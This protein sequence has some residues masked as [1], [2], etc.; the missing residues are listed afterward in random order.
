MQQGILVAFYC[1]YDNVSRLIFVGVYMRITNIEDDIDRKGY[2]IV[3]LE[4]NSKFSAS[5]ESIFKYGIY[6][7]E[8]FEDNK[9]KDIIMNA[10]IDDAYQK[11]FL[12]TYNKLKTT[13]EIKLKL[14]HLGY[15]EHASD[16]AVQRL[17]KRGYLNDEEY[18][19]AFIKN[20]T[21]LST[22]KSRKFLTYELKQKG[23]DTD[24]TERILQ[25]IPNNDNEIALKVVK[26]KYKKI[27]SN[28]VITNKDILKI[29]QFLYNKAF[30]LEDINYALDNLGCDLEES[31]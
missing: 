19:K 25:D 1:I 29:K 8:D 16:M 18:A 23:I 12:T 17:V 9:L 14:V 5:E 30:T 4:D 24:I 10:E 26:K 7:D 22:L 20:A 13:Q 15:S 28:G 3:H 21:K 2:K 27:I 6:V 11:V 31:L